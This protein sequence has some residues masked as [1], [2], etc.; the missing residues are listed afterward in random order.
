M[1][2]AVAFLL[3]K[4][5]ITKDINVLAITTV[6]QISWICWLWH[7]FPQPPPNTSFS[8]MQWAPPGV[9]G[10]QDHSDSSIPYGETW[11]AGEG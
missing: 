4:I 1:L 7:T 3:E 2:A 11:H 6:I 10:Y 8:Y 5:K 9:G